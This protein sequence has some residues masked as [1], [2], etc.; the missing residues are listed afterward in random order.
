MLLFYI[1]FSSFQ[2]KDGQQETE[3]N[4]SNFDTTYYPTSLGPDCYYTRGETAQGK[5]CWIE[6]VISQLSSHTHR[7]GIK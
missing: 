1:T 7:H 4:T 5:I 2:L 3:N 6:Y